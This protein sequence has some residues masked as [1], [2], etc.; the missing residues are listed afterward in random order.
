MKRIVLLD[1]LRGFAI[2][3]TLG[4]NIWI[5]AY[6][7]DLNLVFGNTLEPW[8]SSGD[9]LLQTVML[10][11]VN[12][13]FLGMLTLLFGAGMELKHQK[14]VRDGYRW[15]GVYIWS[16][17][18]L[19]LDG[20]LHYIFVMEYDV[21]MSYAI[22]GMIVSMIIHRSR[23]FIL[24]MMGI[25]G[26]IHVIGV[27]GITAL[28]AFESGSTLNGMDTITQLYASST[29]WEQVIFR[30]NNFVFFRAE[31]IA[32]IPLNIF[33]FLLGAL[34]MRT[35]LFSNDESGRLKRKKL[36]IAGLAAGI[37]LNLLLLIPGGI[38]DIWVRYISA[39][40][41]TLGYLGI[42]AYG[43]EIGRFSRLFKRFGEIGEMAL[44]CYIL[45]NIMASV[46]FYGW[47]LGV[48]GHPSSLFILLS[49]LGICLLLMLF[50]HF[51]LRKYPLGPV[52]WLWRKLSIS[53]A[54]RRTSQDTSI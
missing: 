4:T 33:L 5:F 29:W 47:G 45:Q 34:L 3:G 40:V 51:W 43:L 54:S 25:A 26:S 49:W 46:L 32:I 15:P 31:S 14:A 50:S 19:L 24:I 7:G 10:L 9:R 28:L 12:G 18:L 13:K 11:L 52:E 48:G 2:I 17:A 37:P 35:G 30:L 8:W 27:T 20:L 6:L 53:P 39:P 16:C 41:L 21:L 42:I 44:S 23:R 22:T 38:M 36:M 1:I